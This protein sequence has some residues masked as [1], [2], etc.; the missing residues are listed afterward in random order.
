MILEEVSEANSVGLLCDDVTDIATVE[1]MITFIQY[2][3]K[4]EVSVKFLTAINHMTFVKLSD[5]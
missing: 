3:H 1:Q 2:V 4:G 5:C